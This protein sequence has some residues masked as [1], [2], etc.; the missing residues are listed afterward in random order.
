ML[1]ASPSADVQNG[2]S[3]AAAPRPH[4]PQLPGFKLDVIGYYGGEA[5]T[6][7]AV[8][9]HREVVFDPTVVTHFYANCLSD[10]YSAD[11]RHD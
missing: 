5:S 7:V 1:Q 9:L 6:L 8:K 3:L 10:R 4:S 2:P 11:N